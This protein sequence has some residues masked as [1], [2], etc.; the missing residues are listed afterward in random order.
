MLIIEQKTF[1]V[2]HNLNY[3]DKLSMV[4]GVEA[5]VPYLDRDLVELAGHIPQ[6]FKIKNQVPKYI[7]KKVAEK[8]LP[9]NVIYRSKTGF[10]A[11]V[12][13]LMKNEF[14]EIILKELNKQRLAKD[15]IFNYVKIKEMIENNQND[16]L[17][18]NYNILSLLA[19]Q[20]W[21]KQFPWSM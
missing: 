18:F 12:K 15:G 8:Y 6:K 14:K 2:D 1:L 16:K 20:S 3:T 7:L 21:L 9:K 4:E 17:D 13:R 11:P 5:R 10:G 19:I